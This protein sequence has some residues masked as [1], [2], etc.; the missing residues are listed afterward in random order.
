MSKERIQ[1]V[2]EKEYK[3]IKYRSTLEA[4]TAKV[5][6]TLGIPFSYESRKIV[7]L[8]GFRCPYQKDKVIAI[9]YKPDFNIGHLMLECKGFETPEWKLK[10]KMLFKYLMTNEPDTVYLQTH[11]AKKSLIEALDPYLKE[12][13]FTVSVTT[14]KKVDRKGWTGTEVGFFDSI[15]D[16]M[17]Q[18]GLNGKPKGSIMRSLC[19]DAYVYGYKWKLI[20]DNNE[21]LPN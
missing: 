21:Q 9:T 4:D 1:G 20:K 5:L 6:D 16:A 13:G 12:L 3:G 19:E 17:E 2:R 7:L 11:D 14:K 18:L 8:D 15:Q 10:K